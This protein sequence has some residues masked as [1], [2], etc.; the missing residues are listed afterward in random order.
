MIAF[1]P[2]RATARH[3]VL[4]LV[5]HRKMCA[6]TGRPYPSALAE[7]ERAAS[8]AA[9]VTGPLG[10]E[11]GDQALVVANDAKNGYVLT[12]RQAAAAL[13][14]HPRTIRRMLERDELR[15]IPVGGRRRV[16]RAS[17]EEFVRAPRSCSRHNG[18]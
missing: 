4:A 12:Q 8:E 2:D 11:G 9:S 10:A 18:T 5:R 3:L 7:L 16:A 13:G 1:F 6:A 15:A 14:V 17:L